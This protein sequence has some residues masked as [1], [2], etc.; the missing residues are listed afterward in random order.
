MPMRNHFTAIT[1]I[2]QNINVGLLN[3]PHHCPLC[4]RDID[5]TACGSPVLDQPAARAME[6]VLDLAFRCPNQICSRLFIAR[7]K[8]TSKDNQG[9]Y[10]Y[11]ATEFY[12]QE[13]TDP[14]ICQEVHGVSNNFVKIFTQ[15]SHAE[16][17]SLDQIAGVGYRKALE[18]LIKDY[19]IHENQAE[20]VAIRA[21]FL[22][23]CIKNRVSDPKIQEV[24]KRAAWLGNDETHYTR[25]WD[26]KDIGDLKV[27]IR[28]T[29]SWI[30]SSI[31]T[32]KYLEDMPE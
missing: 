3:W 4:H 28:L 30:E 32:K 16:Q 18:F 15:A 20:E 27:L 24:A 10:Q 11:L 25:K 13:L 31:L 1:P 23:Q 7:C 17:H 2:G 9:R 21:E 22:G 14:T 6:A 19:C 5:P 29:V 26:D 12:P 8:W